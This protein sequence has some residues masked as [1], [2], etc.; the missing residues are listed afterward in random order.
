[1]Q[2]GRPGHKGGIRSF[3][4]VKG[5]LKRLLKQ[6][7]AVKVSTLFDRYGLPADW[8]GLAESKMKTDVAQAHAI[9]CDAM[10]KHICAEMGED[11]R[12]ERFV[13][14][15]QFYE[16]E[17]LLFVKPDITAN[18]LGNFAREGLL[19]DAVEKSGGCEFIND[20]H[21]TA[22][23]KRIGKWFPNYKK[24]KG[25]NAHLPHICISVGLNEL[26]SACPMF[27]NWIKNLI[28]A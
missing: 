5:D 22:P 19:R 10:H 21:D 27:D 14:Y 20:G 9:I 2:V 23:S 11:F 12:P 8:P 16:L 6:E 1:V 13:P 26:R 15:I 28:A 4:A 25:V 3:E 17:A 24:G 18:L 7:A